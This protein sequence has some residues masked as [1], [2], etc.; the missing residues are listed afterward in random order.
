M[1]GG[2]QRTPRFHSQS[3]SISS[4]RPQSRPPGGKLPTVCTSRDDCPCGG[5]LHMRSHSQPHIQNHKLLHILMSCAR[6]CMC[7]THAFTTLHTAVRAHTHTHTHVRIACICST[8]TLCPFKAHI[9][10]GA[11]T[12][13]QTHSF[14]ISDIWVNCPFKTFSA[15]LKGT[16]CSPEAMTEV[17]TRTA[18]LQ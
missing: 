5:P 1:W 18:T 14:K 15:D 17:C 9:H 6:T 2:R 4:G 8:L 12:H 13:A 7:N 3:G 10:A 11:R 16:E